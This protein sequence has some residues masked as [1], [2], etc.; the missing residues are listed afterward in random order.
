MPGVDLLG[1]A[2]RGVEP[3]PAGRMPASTIVCWWGVGK[4][5]RLGLLGGQRPPPGRQDARL[6]NRLPAGC[7]LGGWVLLAV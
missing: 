5:W 2:A 1:I 3:R 7:R 4:H 6:H